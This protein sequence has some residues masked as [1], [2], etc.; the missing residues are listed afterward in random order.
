MRQMK[1]EEVDIE[2]MSNS[3]LTFESSRK[4]PIEYFI[5]S[6]LKW[7]AGLTLF[8]VVINIGSLLIRDEQFFSNEWIHYFPLY[9]CVFERLIRPAFSKEHG[10][11]AY[12]ITIDVDNRFLEFNYTS[13]FFLNR[14]RKYKFEEVCVEQSDEKI[15]FFTKPRTPICSAVK[16]E[17]LFPD[18]AFNN[19]TEKLNLLTHKK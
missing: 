8:C 16:N 10:R 7:W 11:L 15:M 17:R 5:V 14:L 18:N 3:P 13:F 1:N 4:Y 9:I 2:Q 19:L 6:F 12:K